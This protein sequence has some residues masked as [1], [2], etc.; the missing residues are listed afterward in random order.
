[1]RIL[2]LSLLLIFGCED[3][4]NTILE[5]NALL[6]WTGDYAVD[7]CGFFIDIDDH[8]YKP[9]DEMT[10]DDSLKINSGVEVM[11]QYELLNKTIEYNCGDLPHFLE[12]D[13][14]KL[15]SIRKI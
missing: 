11:I 15:H 13:G 3:K 1:M 4:K 10:I 8:E 12:V 7:G 6:R 5:A 2:L 9:E 14:I